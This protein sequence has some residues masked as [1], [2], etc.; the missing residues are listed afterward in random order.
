MT[1]VFKYDFAPTRAPPIGLPNL[2]LPGS[3]GSMAYDVM[4][5]ANSINWLDILIFGFA[6]YGLVIGLPRIFKFG[7]KWINKNSPIRLK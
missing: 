3:F 4:S 2:N 5:L 7:K 1:N 6:G